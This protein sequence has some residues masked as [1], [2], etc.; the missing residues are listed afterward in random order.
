MRAIQKHFTKTAIAGIVALMPIVGIVLTVYYAETTISNSWLARQPYYFPG[1]G[2]I[3]A[4]VVIYLIG[5]GVSNVLGRWTLNVIDKLLDNVPA[6]G[7]LYQTVKQILG[8]G[9]GPNALFIRVVMVRASDVPGEELGFVTQEIID[10]ATGA[11]KAI[12]FI[13]FSPTPTN[14]RLVLLDEQAMRPVNMSVNEAFKTSIALGKTDEMVQ[15]VE[16]STHEAT[17][18]VAVNRSSRITPAGKPAAICVLT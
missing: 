1:L 6:L 18:H 9:E 16:C 3:A 11:R 17:R 4:A 2:I 12:V 7:A 13:P 10:E 15:S 5:L 8:Y 14:G